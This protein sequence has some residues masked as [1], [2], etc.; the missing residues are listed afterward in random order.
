[1]A[2]SFRPSFVMPYMTARTDAVQQGLF[3]RKFGVP[4]WGLA[5]ALGRDP[6][7][8]YRMECGLG[9]ASLVGTTVRRVPLPL[10]LLADEHH[11]QRNGDKT[12]LATTVGGGCCL[13][14]EPTDAAG[15]PELTAA[16][17]TFR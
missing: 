6:M 15:T 4:F 9:R 3:L 5:H 13:G 7:F 2:Y 11:Q 14:L 1:T 12:Y 16:Y 17:G 10:H 8:W